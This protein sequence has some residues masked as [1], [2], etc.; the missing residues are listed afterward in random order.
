VSN[1]GQKDVEE[2]DILYKNI[3]LAQ[4]A[5]K[6]IIS[7]DIEDFLESKNEDQLSLTEKFGKYNN[8]LIINNP[9]KANQLLQFCLYTSIQIPKSSVTVQSN[10]KYQDRQVGLQTLKN[11]QLP[12]FVIQT[13]IEK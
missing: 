7:T 4:S 8:F 13:Y 10:G 3:Q 2:N 1:A 5:T 11:I 6:P 12:D 9:I